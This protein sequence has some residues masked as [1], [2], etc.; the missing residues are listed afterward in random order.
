MRFYQE[1]TEA[2]DEGSVIYMVDPGMALPLARERLLIEHAHLRTLEHLELKQYKGT[3]PAGVLLVLPR[4]FA[5][6]GKLSAIQNSFPGM[7][8]W[9]RITLDS[10]KGWILEQGTH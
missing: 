2:A 6:N 9:Q 1:V 10:Q 3:P 8:R 4:E 7:R 5:A